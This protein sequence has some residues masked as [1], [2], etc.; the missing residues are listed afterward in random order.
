M[1]KRSGAGEDGFLGAE[2]TGPVPAPAWGWTET[3][4]LLMVV[5]WGVNFSVVKR[6]LEAFDPMGFNAL[7][8]PIASLF[9]LV[10]VRAQGPLTAPERGDLP[11]VLVLGLLGNVFYQMGFILGLDRTLAG[12]ASLMLALTP[13]ITALLSAWRGH[14]RPGGRTWAGAALAVLGVGLVTGSALTFQGDARVFTGD[15]ILLG[16]AVMWAL[17]TVGSR[18]LVEKYGS[19]PVTA[20]TLWT[21]TLGLL[22]VGAPA[23]V[24]QEWGRVGAEAWGGL[25]FSAVFSIGLSYLIW[26]RGVERIG[27]TRTA[28]FSNLTPVVALAFGALWLGERPGP[29]ALLGA[30]VTLGGIVLVRTDP[31][32]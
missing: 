22:A 12:H 17:Y 7:R 1:T 2:A 15:L 31:G 6:A 21:G 28:V 13:V 3:S 32:R 19:V 10:V 24:A 11:K 16:A 25:L 8:Y 18:P 27:N 29:L 9:V 26:Y 23:L 14:E 4:L 20:W 30:G 5:V